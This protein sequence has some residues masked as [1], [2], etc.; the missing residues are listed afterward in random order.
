VRALVV[1]KHG[2]PEVLKIQ[3]RP[4]PEVGAGQV[5]VRVRA[6]GINFADLMARMGLYPD[7]PKPPCV[8]GYEIAGEVD[9]VGQGVEGFAPGDRVMGGTR[10]GGHAE[11]AVTAPD[12]LQPLPDGW[13]FEEGAAMPV[14]YATAYAGLVRY[15]A[16]H[17]GER[18]L[19]HAAAGGVGIAA[20]QI[21]KLC[22]AEVYG[23]ASAS[24][25]DAI[26]G[27]GVDHPIDYRSQDFVE[28]VR[29]IAGEEEPLD[30][31]MDAI[32]GKS[33]KRSYSLLRAGGRLV[34]FG[35]AGLVS[36]DRRDIPR[37]LKTLA[38]SPRFS[39]LKLA[40]ESKAVIGLNMLRLWDAKGS[41]EE[42]AE[43]L[44]KWVE[45]GE[46]RPVVAE[47]FP[48]E[49]AADAHRLMQERKNVGKVVLKL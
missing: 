30:L 25:H 18:V 49:R 9:S 27:F 13:S 29:R 43:P 32:G 19:V 2:P 38:Q 41:I 35:A 15:G 46:I 34:C 42:F 39:S 48:L 5:R 3:E 1:T 21:A 4:D 16:L 37:T 20:V 7:A 44:R 26:R 40:S 31:V 10:F 28:E 36:G 8:V 23:T 6:A 17:E 12:V 14:N 24:K 11:L 22:G 45:N 33:F 47:A